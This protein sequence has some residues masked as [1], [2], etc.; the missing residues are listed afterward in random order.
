MTSPVQ[1]SKPPQVIIIC[2]V[3]GSGKTFCARQYVARGYRVISADQLI[4]DRYDSDFLTFSA[5][6]R[7]EIFMSADSM[8]VEALE[9]T[10]SLGA[11]AVVDAPLCKRFQRDKIRQLCRRRGVSSIL[12]YCCPAPEVIRERLSRRSGLGPHDQKVSEQEL[13]GFLAN[14]EAPGPDEKP[15]LMMQQIIMTEIPV[16]QMLKVY[17][18]VERFEQCCRQCENYGK[19]WLCPPFD[20]DTTEK[21][22]KWQTVLIAGIKVELPEKTPPDWDITEFLQEPRNIMENKLLEL[23]QEYGGLSC[24]LTSMC[25]FCPACSRPEGKPCRFPEK[26]RPSLEAYG[27]DVCKIMEEVLGTPLEW[28]TRNRPQRTMTLVGALF[29]NQLPGTIKFQL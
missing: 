6:R 28:A 3:S 18:D 27:F 4:W 15:I 7:Q 1:D 17:R 16:E 23:E 24:G 20:F 9:T 25:K 5:E 22:Q 10:L 8:I 19:S 2:G 14:F 29:H 13:A 11:K 26:A 12:I 21:L